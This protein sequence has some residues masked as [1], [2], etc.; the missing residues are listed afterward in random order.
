MCTKFGLRVVIAVRVCFDLTI[1]S[2]HPHIRTFENTDIGGGSV[3][4]GT[5]HNLARISLR[6]MI[7]E[8]FKTNS[9]IMFDSAAL[10]RIGLD[11]AT[12]YPKVLER[13]DAITSLDIPRSPPSQSLWSRLFSTLTPTQLSIE[14]S[15]SLFSRKHADGATHGDTNDA[16]GVLEVGTEEEEDLKDCLMPKFDQLSLKWRWWVLEVVP[17]THRYQT[18]DDKWHTW[19]GWNVGRGRYIPR[20]STKG[21]HMHRTVKLRRDAY[22]DPSTKK[23]YTPHAMCDVEPKYVG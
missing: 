8:T 7:R 3:K 9:G 16:A 13:P 1:D 20:Q 14:H 23:D 15:R 5:P 2:A 22:I 10:K 4:N 18:K 12:L 6:W 19:F 17:L 21:V 11:P